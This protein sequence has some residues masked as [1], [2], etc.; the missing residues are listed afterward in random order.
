MARLQKDK[1]DALIEVIQRNEVKPKWHW[2]V[3]RGPVKA[4]KGCTGPGCSCVKAVDKGSKE[5]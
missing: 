4:H 1:M 5:A 2:L 3:M